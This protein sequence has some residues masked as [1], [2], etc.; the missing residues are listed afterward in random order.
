MRTVS[1]RRF[2]P[3]L[4]AVTLDGLAAYGQTDAGTFVFAASVQAFERRE[5]LLGVFGLDADPVVLYSENQ[6]PVSAL[7]RQVNVRSL[8]ARE[9][10]RIREQ[11]LIEL[12]QHGSVSP[13]LG[14]LIADDFSLAF[15]YSHGQ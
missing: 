12:R 15:L 2:N 11:V 7:C 3:D 8:G 9:L 1:R 10:Q 6:L 5:D 14:K 13:H 4:T